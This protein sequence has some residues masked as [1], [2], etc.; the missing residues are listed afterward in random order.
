MVERTQIRKIILFSIENG[1]SYIFI[2]LWKIYQIDS[3]IYSGCWKHT[4]K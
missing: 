4:S 2:N 3:I 1:D